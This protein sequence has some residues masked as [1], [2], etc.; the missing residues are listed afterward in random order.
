MGKRHRII[1][2]LNRVAPGDVTACEA[3]RTDIRRAI[4]RQMAVRNLN[5]NA[6]ALLVAGRVHRSHVYDFIGGRKELTTEKANH[7]LNAL[8]MEIVPGDSE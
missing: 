8:G 5:T 7:L 6:L 1:G 3:K 2:R 4:T